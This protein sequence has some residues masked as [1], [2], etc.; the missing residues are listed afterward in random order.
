MAT[1]IQPRFAAQ[2]EHM[3][4]TVTTGP[5]GFRIAHV[6]VGFYHPISDQRTK[7]DIP[8]WY[9]SPEDAH[10]IMREARGLTAAML[11]TVFGKVV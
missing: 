8:L 9:G 4:I 7:K 11:A 5:I 2:L 3:P 1:T 10:R 6:S